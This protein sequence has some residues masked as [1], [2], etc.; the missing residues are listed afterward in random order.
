MPNPLA[1]IRELGE[2][3]QRRA[4][5]GSGEFKVIDKTIGKS[6]LTS[7][8]VKRNAD[9][10][11]KTPLGLDTRNKLKSVG[12]LT[13][14]GKFPIFEKEKTPTSFGELLV[15]KHRVE[16]T[17][18]NVNRGDKQ[19]RTYEVNDRDLDLIFQDPK[20]FMEQQGDFTD[21]DPESVE[22]KFEVNIL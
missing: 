18:R 6:E 3:F 14:V 5:K 11:S 4:G 1:A 2:F 13:S 22:H 19:T 20:G 10:F 7:G 16:I 8:Y 15:P 21:S 17:R 12:S 9:N